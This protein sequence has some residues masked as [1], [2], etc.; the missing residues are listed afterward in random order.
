MTRAAKYQSDDSGSNP[1]EVDSIF[2]QKLA[3][4]LENCNKLEEPKEN[5][6]K[7]KNITKNLNTS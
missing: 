6:T 4:I 3:R 5:L 7:F 2:H 1:T